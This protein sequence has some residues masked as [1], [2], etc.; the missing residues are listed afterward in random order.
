M[1]DQQKCFPCMCSSRWHSKLHFHCNQQKKWGV[2]FA[3]IR[4][5]RKRL[6]LQVLNTLLG[7]AEFPGKLHMEAAL[8][9]GMNCC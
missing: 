8:Q 6:C 4:L 1:F 9:V 5:R 2:N 7:G 3:G